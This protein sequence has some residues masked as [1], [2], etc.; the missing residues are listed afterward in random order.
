MLVHDRITRLSPY[1]YGD[2]DEY[3]RQNR[4]AFKEEERQLDGAT[5]FCGGTR[6]TGDAFGGGG[7]KSTDPKACSDHDHPKTDA[8]TDDI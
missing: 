4:H 1:K 3:F 2:E 5:D 6:L 7:G 8:D